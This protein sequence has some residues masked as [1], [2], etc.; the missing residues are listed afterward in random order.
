[1]SPRIW[2]ALKDK[3]V[4][5][6]IREMRNTYDNVKAEFKRKMQS[7]EAA[8]PHTAE[9]AMERSESRMSPLDA[10]SLSSKPVRQRCPWT[11]SDLSLR[12]FSSK[13]TAHLRFWSSSCMAASMVSGSTPGSTRPFFLLT[14]ESR[15]DQERTSSEA[16]R[17]ADD[18]GDEVLIVSPKVHHSYPGQTP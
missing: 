2:K 9:E 17:G 1:M 3:G 13:S 14:A 18:R 16:Y 6:V 5:A 12:L 8:E 10:S 7:A 15:R 4:F 11:G